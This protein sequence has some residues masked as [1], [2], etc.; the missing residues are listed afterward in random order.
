M[1]TQ[2]QKAQDQYELYEYCR[3]EGGHDR[4]L[5]DHEIA[6]RYYASK[7]W[8]DNDEKERTN[9]GKLS[10]V[11]NE[12]FRTINAVRGELNQ[13]SS[14]VRFDP[15]NGDPNT[16]RVLNRL[17]EHVDRQ[18]K[19][20]M[21]DDRVLLDGLL[22]GRGYWRQRVKFDD[23]MQGHIEIVR[24]RPENVILDYDIESPDPDTW[25]RV[26][27]TEIVSAEDIENMFGKDAGK[28]FGYMPIA[29]WLSPEDR[30]LGQSI[31]LKTA[32]HGDEVLGIKRYRLISHQFREY[33]YKDCFVDKA[34]GDMSEVPENWSREK[35]NYALENFNLGIVRRKVKTLRWR[36]TC[37]THVLHDDD[38]PYKHFD[39]VPFFPWFTDDTP[40]SLFAV[41]KG[42]QDLLNYTVSEETYILANTAHSGWKVKQG[43]LKNMT[44][45]DLERKGG[46]NGVVLVLDEPS[47]AE[48]ITPGQPATA[49]SQ[50]GDRARGWINDLGSVTSSMLGAQ[51]EYANG[52]NIGANLQRAPVNLHAPLTAFQFGKQLLAERKLNLFQTVYTETRIL[53]VAT[54]AYGQTEELAINLPTVD[55][56]LHDLTVGSYSVRMLPV[57]SRQAADE[58]AFDQLALMKEMGINVPNSLFVSTSNINAKAD[59]IEQ[60]LEANSG[61]LSPEEQRLRELEVELAELD[62][63]DKR[64][65]IE[66]KL[67]AADLASGRAERARMDASF[68]PRVHRAQL[69]EQRLASEH[70][71]GV[72]QIQTQQQRDARNAAV[73]ITKLAVDAAK[74]KPAPAGSKPAAKKAAKKVS[75]KAPAKK[76]PKK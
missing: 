22:G 46:Q 29:D 47:D 53:R 66:G 41:L 4:Y 50:F 39:I 21:H 28:E 13:L 60:L 37:N 73:Q 12:V 35:I 63:E 31:G 64:A 76:S 24:Q 43:S 7:Q 49:F 20:Y 19:V 2:A 56:I 17:N 40:L 68:D 59:V 9:K 33:K 32:D 74:P 23:N 6:K 61:E 16:A 57:G 45:R 8:L 48:R 42:P 67:A 51:S 75:K 11:V 1:A 10:F 18:N 70:E 71:R 72:R 5:R 34:T 36:V 54:S 55:G 69:D 27:Y 38:S 65:G 52:K 44:T 62:V 58:F 30:S 25:A 3:V 26:F 15:T 14:D